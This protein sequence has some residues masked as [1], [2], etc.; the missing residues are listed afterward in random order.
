MVTLLAVVVVAVAAAQVRFEPITVAPLYPDGSRMCDGIV[1]DGEVVLVGGEGMILRSRDGFQTWQRQRIAEGEDR[2]I[3]SIAQVTPDVWVVVGERG[4][5]Y[6]SGDR[7][8]SWEA[9]GMPTERTLYR[10]RKNGMGILIAV[11]AGGEIVRS[12]DQG[13]TW[14]RR[15]SGT[16]KDLWSVAWQGNVA[17]AVGE[18]GVIVRST[19]GGY[20]WRVVRKEDFLKRTLYA[21]AA[22]DADRWYAVGE[23]MALSRTSDGGDTWGTQPL[24][25]PLS[26]AEKLRGIGFWDEQ[27][28]WITGETSSALWQ[29]V[30]K[31]TDGGATWQKVKFRIDTVQIPPGGTWTSYP[32]RWWGML[33]SGEQ[34]LVYGERRQYTIVGVEPVE[35]GKEWQRRVWDRIV[36]LS[37]VAGAKLEG[38][39]EFLALIGYPSAPQVVRYRSSAG[40]WDTVSLLP[41]IDVWRDTVYAQFKYYGERP[42]R[43]VW[44]GQSVFVLTF[45]SNGWWST[46]GG[47]TWT[48]VQLDSVGISKAFPYGERGFALAGYIEVPGTYCTIGVC[49]VSEEPGQPW[50]EVLRLDTGMRLRG[51][52]FWDSQQGYAVVE[53]DQ[54]VAFWTTTDG[55]A[56]W[57]KRAIPNA[58]QHY[59]GNEIRFS[60]VRLVRMY[61]EQHI[62]IVLEAEVLVPGVPYINVGLL[63]STDGGMTW[64]HRV[65]FSQ[66]GVQYEGT[67][68]ISFA[69][70][71]VSTKMI[72]TSGGTSS[73][74]VLYTQDGQTWK[75]IQLPEPGRGRFD[76]DY[77]GYCAIVWRNGSMFSNYNVV[78]HQLLLI[79]F[80]TTGVEEAQQAVRDDGIAAYP[81][82]ATEKL[83]LQYS[84]Q[85]HR[86]VASVSLYTA[87]GQLVRQYRGAIESVDVRELASGD[88]YLV[89]QLQSGVQHIVVVP[90][91][92]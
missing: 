90:V 50:R 82:P 61:N 10:V 83:F 87:D 31:T 11:G 18:D 28:G 23:Q 40:V 43:W 21:V 9:I 33:R 64:E 37:T 60:Q 76:W 69:A 34:Q 45:Y 19:D 68:R 67:S 63:S 14:E 88:Y 22:A 89:V 80:G 39:D 54:E 29:P 53:S 38:C 49:L 75:K 59:T 12:S 65:W 86:M 72:M 3:Y 13:W 2:T 25:P 36:P 46:D 7:G 4:L 81:V 52:R 32:I 74:S 62:D 35:G 73:G 41:V 1:V 77:N 71:D 26:D 56:H 58:R 51:V 85:I 70:S 47:K 44:N 55:G 91:V 20:T 30:W 8:K 17:M 66:F 42:T 48:V 57:E 5:C 6:R 27:H 92:R 84:T 78:P 79:H 16:A 15:V 24:V